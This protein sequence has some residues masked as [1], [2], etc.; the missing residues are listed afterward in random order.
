MVGPSHSSIYRLVSEG[1]FPSHSRLVSELRGGGALISW[2][3]KIALWTTADEFQ[4]RGL[5][6]IVRNEQTA[7][8]RCA[9]IARH[10]WIGWLSRK[11]SRLLCFRS[12]STTLVGCMPLITATLSALGIP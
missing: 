11:S 4:Q 7:L 9:T 12:P 10:Q 3:G 5:S 2:N 1:R 6:Q 8:L